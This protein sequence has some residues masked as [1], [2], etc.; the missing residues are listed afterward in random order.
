M[1]IFMLKYHF[2][3][4]YLL[5]FVL[6]ISV[7]ICC[8]EARR[9]LQESASGSANNTDDRRPMQDTRPAGDTALAWP[10]NRRKSQPSD[11][12]HGTL[13]PFEMEHM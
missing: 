13:F 6:Q 8:S 3:W 1:Q 2:C 7:S 12:N 9:S 5:P 11:K 10:Q 4:V